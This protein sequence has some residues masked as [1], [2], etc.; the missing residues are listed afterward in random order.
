[1][2]KVLMLIA[3][4]ASTGAFAKTPP[5]DVATAS[6]RVSGMVEDGVASW[7]GIPFAAPPI[8]SL[9]WRAPQPPTPWRDVRPAT[10]Y[11]NDC[12]QQPFRGDAAPMGA[13][14]AEDCLYLNVW[15]P[16]AASAK[17]P[18]IL[19]IYGGGF[20]NGG[21]S[22]PTYAGANLARKGVV[23]VSF[24]YRLGRFGTFGHP[25]L[26]QADADKGLLVNYGFMDQIA[27]LRWVK[28]N[29]ARFGGDP[30]NITVMGESAGGMSVHMLLTSPLS[31]GLF[32]RAVVMSG[33]NGQGMGSN[34]APS[35][36]TELATAEA[37]GA[38]FAASKGVPAGEP[39]TLARLRGM[40][41]EQ[42]TDG[43]S[44]IQLFQPGKRSFSS[45]IVDG[46]VAVPVIP[47]YRSRR[48]NR[49]PVMIGATSGDIGGPA[50][51]MI[52]G[53]R[54]IS[55][56]LEE[57]GVPTYAYRFSYVAEAVRGTSALSLLAQ[58]ATDVPFFFDTQAVKYGAATTARDKA[59]G[60]TISSYIA[61]FA[62]TGNPNGKDLPQW[63]R[64]ARATDVIMDFALDGQAH[65]G[66]DQLT[67]QK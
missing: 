29:I 35:P 48:F 9:R 53:A 31:Q 4:I 59:V 27:A 17:M 3:A 28:A 19:W 16:A 61:N 65:A 1:M 64:Y 47:A 20:V 7:K 34:P 51:P 54:Q 10:A 6:G 40:T 66:K 37:T 5:Q 21:S 22:P 43:L 38:E 8:G 56:V 36:A 41:A 18:V 12:M 60:G 24:N 14:P 2:K 49:V 26:T 62:R 25:A 57:A 44:L 58:H 13:P 15:K 33:G 67:P 11:R 23:F 46:K 50:G 42:V 52:A 30:G 45:P 39:D 55:Q 63:P 32:Q